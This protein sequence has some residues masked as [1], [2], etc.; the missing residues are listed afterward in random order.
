MQDYTLALFQP[1]V[2]S[3][4]QLLING[5]PALDLTLFDVEDLTIDGQL[6]DPAIRSQP[7]SLIFH[8]PLSPFASQGNHALMHAQLGNLEMFL[9]PIGPDRKT[10][11][12]MQYQAIY[13]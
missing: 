10:G 3:L 12:N 6:R 11:R 2:G 5:Q 1:L 8:G 7:F 9:V 4:F 13:N